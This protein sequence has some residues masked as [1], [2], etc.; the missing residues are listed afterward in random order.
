MT[1]FTDLA[2]FLGQLITGFRYRHEYLIASLRE[3]DVQFYLQKR[4]SAVL[5]LANGRLR[6]QYT[7]LKVQ[8]YPVFGIDLANQRL[9]LWEETAYWVARRIF[10]HQASI[11]LTGPKDL[12]LTRGN[13]GWLP[14]AAR[15]FDLVTSVAAFEHFLHVP[16]VVQECCRVLKPGGIIWI[17][18]HLFTCPSGGHNVKLM[19]IPLRSLPKGVEPWDHLRK[20][21]L[22]FHVPLNEWRIHQYLEAFARHF[23]IVKHYCAMR[24]G[25]YLP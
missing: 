12:W 17:V 22:P 10:T 20:R 13:V 18:V 1:P 2:R 4:T 25:E 8:G 14:F 11:H 7:L 21:R 16:L 23:E 15:S 9:A 3:R 5:D 24:E 19:E 6:P